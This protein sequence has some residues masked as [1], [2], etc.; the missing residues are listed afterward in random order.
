MKEINGE[1]VDVN[2]ETRADFYQALTEFG[3]CLKVALQSAS[4]YED[5][6]FSDWTAPRQCCSRNAGTA[7]RPAT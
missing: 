1:L 5:S 6:A 2:L 7:S 3:G 4:F